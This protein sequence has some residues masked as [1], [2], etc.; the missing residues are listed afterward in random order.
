MGT[1]HVKSLKKNE[2]W[3]Q[4]RRNSELSMALT[5]ANICSSLRAMPI[6]DDDVVRMCRS[7][8][9]GSDNRGTKG[10]RLGHLVLGEP[11]SD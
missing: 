9:I 8:L 7:D 6:L 5:P 10:V 3:L 4:L 1:R 11:V 2:K